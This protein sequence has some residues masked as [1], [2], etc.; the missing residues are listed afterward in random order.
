[1]RIV[2]GKHRSRILN[3]FQLKNKSDLRPTTDKNRE[4][5]FNILLNS[6]MLK[7][8]GFNL[9]G[10]NILDGFC[11]T[12]AVGLEAISR[13]AK[14]VTFI[15]NNKSHINLAKQNAELLKESNNCEF[16]VGDITNVKLPNNKEY[17]LIFLDPPYRKDLLTKSLENIAKNIKLSENAII[18]VEHAADEK[19]NYCDKFSIMDTRKYGNSIFVFLKLL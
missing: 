3:D 19:M 13:G 5:M 11:G 18:L 6:S 10:A 1:M 8:I 4:S 7:E 2:G 17:D 14:F 16:I 12:G 15:D 9:I